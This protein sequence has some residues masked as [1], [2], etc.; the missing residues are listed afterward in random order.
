[1]RAIP[2]LGSGSGGSIDTVTTGKPATTAAINRRRIPTA[3]RDS[4]DE[5]PPRRDSDNEP[6]PR[7]DSDN[8]PPPRRN[9]DNE[10][11]PRGPLLRSS[12]LNSGEPSV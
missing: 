7:R 3:R 11:P 6:P 2:T 1:M 4:D 9:S 8:E 12:T 5:P 10:P